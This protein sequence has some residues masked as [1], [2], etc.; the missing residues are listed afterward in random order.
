MSIA[1][2]DIQEKLYQFVGEEYLDNQY[3]LL[4]LFRFFGR[5]PSTRFSRLAMVHALDSGKA[6]I[7]R[8]LKYL[9]KKGLVKTNIENNIPLYSLTENKSLRSFVLEI[10]ELDWYQ[11]QLVLGQAHT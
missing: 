4:E 6:Q 3:C 11:W 8:V 10:A 1:A 2:V 5:H 9:V 7:E